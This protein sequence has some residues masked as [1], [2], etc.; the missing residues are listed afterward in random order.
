MNRI[1]Y[2]AAI[3]VLSFSMCNTHPKVDSLTKE[4]EQAY[5]DSAHSVLM[6]MF[7][8]D[9]VIQWPVIRDKVSN[10]YYFV[11]SSERIVSDTFLMHKAQFNVGPVRK[12]DSGSV[13]FTKQ[14][15]VFM[16]IILNAIS[17]QSINKSIP[18]VSLLTPDVIRDNQLLNN[19]YKTLT[20]PLFTPDYQTAIVEINNICRPQCG[21]GEMLILKRE[22]NGWII[23][24][25]IMTWIN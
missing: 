21:Y 8:S 6:W 25:R 13:I 10:K 9:S 19:Y 23:I 3:S 7:N 5:I 22:N 2:L 16:K 17:G 1:L 12:V 11:D 4:Q 18:K 15:T 14:D 20:L 24:Q